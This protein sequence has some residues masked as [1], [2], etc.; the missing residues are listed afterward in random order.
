M[1]DRL[2][3]L[4]NALSC[5][6][7]GFAA[8]IAWAIW[9]QAFDVALLLLFSACVTDLLDGWLARRF[10][11]QSRLGAFLDPAADKILIG[12]T[13]L[14]LSWLGH[15]AVWLA[16][17]VVGR[18]VLIAGGALTFRVLYGPFEH[19]ATALGKVSTLLQMLL[20]VVVVAGLGVGAQWQVYARNA[21]AVLIALVVVVALCSG[22][23]YVWTWSRRAAHTTRGAGT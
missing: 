13:F 9:Q 7:L 16:A 3:W 6:R 19:A 20:I 15:V 18:D 14:M 8:P 1:S 17:L 23:D 2:R 4:P 5:L 22:A 12:A 11:W 21:A 10:A